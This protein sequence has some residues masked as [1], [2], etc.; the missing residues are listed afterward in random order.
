MSMRNKKYREAKFNTKEK[1]QIEKI[2]ESGRF[3]FA[4]NCYQEYLEKYPKDRDAFIRYGKL[5][6]LLNNSQ[7]ASEWMEFLLLELETKEKVGFALIECIYLYLDQYDFDNAYKYFL[8]FQELSSVNEIFP[9]ALNTS[10]MRI[11]LKKKLGIYI[12]TLRREEYNYFERQIIHYEEEELLSHTLIYNLYGKSA[13][14]NENPI[15]QEH[16]DIKFLYEEIKRLLPLA[17][18]TPNYNVFDT[19]L[20]F[21]SNV[22]ISKGEI[23]NYFKVCVI[24]DEE[25]YQIV[26]FLPCKPF[27]YKTFINDFEK[28]KLEESLTFKREKTLLAK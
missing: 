7:G 16:I 13:F 1:M 18:K 26:E 20:F 11:L 9:I 28:L 14:C 23:L 4:L 27:Q 15:F 17:M 5:L 21:Y 3:H 25:K 2:I 19:Y 22:G 8:Q 12:P 6:R 10:L 24:P